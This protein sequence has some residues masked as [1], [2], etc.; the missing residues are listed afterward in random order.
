MLNRRKL[1]AFAINSH[2]GNAGRERRRNAKSRRCYRARVARSLG[3]SQ[4][5]GL[6][7]H[8]RGIFPDWG[9][10]LSILLPS[11]APPAQVAREALKADV[12]QELRSLVEGHAVGYDST[13]VLRVRKIRISSPEYE[14]AWP[15]SDPCFTAVLMDTS[16]GRVVVL[17]Q[18][19]VLDGAGYW[20]HWTIHPDRFR[21]TR[22]LELTAARW[23]ATWAFPGPAL[24]RL[25][26]WGDLYKRTFEG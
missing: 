11:N 18:Y 2:S 25:A 16:N 6:A 26:R 12:E 7:A 13:K 24:A 1:H 23:S 10:Q 15:G 22:S 9:I 4:V 17:L 20:W 21:S 19:V 3:R 8:R 5:E 14:R